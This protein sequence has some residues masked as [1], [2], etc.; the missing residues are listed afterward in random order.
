M[1]LSLRSVAWQDN[2]IPRDSAWL[3]DT[4]KWYQIWYNLFSDTYRLL[5]AHI[6]QSPAPPAIEFF[7]LP[8]VSLPDSRLGFLSRCRY[9]TLVLQAFIFFMFFFSIT[10]HNF[11]HYKENNEILPKNSNL[12][13]IFLHVKKEKKGKK[14]KKTLTLL[15]RQMQDRIIPREALLY[16]KASSFRHFLLI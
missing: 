14:Y 8:G 6:C 12:L 1:F 7:C 2:V 15:K 4:Q 5:G 3:S 10:S 9:L 16:Y 11:I 13:L